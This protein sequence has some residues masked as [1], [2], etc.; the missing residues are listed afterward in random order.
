MS[1]F[2][3]AKSQQAFLKAGVYGKSG[4]GKTYT[5]LLIAEGLAKHCGKRIAFIDTEHGSDFYAQDIKERT[6]HPAA[7]DFDAMYSKSIIDVLDSVKNLD[8]NVYGI[9]VL[10][11]IT[12]IW[13]AAKNAYTGRLM[14]NG[15]IPMHA[16]GE[17]KKP[18][19]ELISIMID[20][21]YHVLF[22]GRLGMDY[23]EGDDGE[24]KSVGTK[25]KAEGET[26]YEPHILIRMESVKMKN[27]T[28]IPTAYIEKDR[29]GILGG[30]KFPMPTFETLIKPLLVVFGNEQAKME[31]EEE[32]SE[33]DKEAIVKKKMEKKTASHDILEEYTSKIKLI[34]DP[35]EL[36]TLG[37]DIK[38]AK[39][40]MMA[41]DVFILREVYL[42]R[43]AKLKPAAKPKGEK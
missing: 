12:H 34:K 41:D 30:Q 5:S 19:K 39:K 28:S 22:C 9:L 21:N 11:S 15:Q 4:S 29:T 32:T 3:K 8:E 35:K 14:S 20:C 16:W 40:K 25:M 43:E 10:D 7:F 38:D 27:N 1:P 2:R 26:A 37:K 18:Y 24:L 42:E 33:K 31:S 13:E 17:I 6:H 23:Q 36:K